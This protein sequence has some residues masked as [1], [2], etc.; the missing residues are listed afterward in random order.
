MLDVF[1]DPT[2]VLWVQSNGQHRGNVCYGGLLRGSVVP[3]KFSC[4]TRCVRKRRRSTRWL[5]Y[6]LVDCVSRDVTLHRLTTHFSIAVCIS[7]RV[8]QKSVWHIIH[9][10]NLSQSAVS[11]S[12]ARTSHRSPWALT[13]RMVAE[14][15]VIVPGF[16][17]EIQ[18]STLWR[19]LRSCL[20]DWSIS[21]MK[22]CKQDNDRRQRNRRW[23]WLNSV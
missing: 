18:G 14:L 9:V 12:V 1:C 13:S 3:A 7:M 20:R 22:P 5:W 6:K 4:A 10:L 17:L 16:S 21:R 15:L 23:Q 8:T 11:A 19:Q 2:F